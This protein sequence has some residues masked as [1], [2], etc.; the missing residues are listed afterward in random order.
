[1]NQRASLPD[2]AAK[3]G[4]SPH[5]WLLTLPL[6]AAVSVPASNRSSAHDTPPSSPASEE[7]RPYLTAISVAPFRFRDAVPPP[8]LTVRLPAGAP[9]EPGPAPSEKAAAPAPAPVA[10]APD[11]TVQPEPRD[12]KP[13][14]EPTPTEQPKSFAPILP[15][16]TRPK[17]R[18]EDFLP[19]FQYPNSSNIDVSV[20]A[21]ASP[22][23]MPNSS[24]SYRQQ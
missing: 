15:D 2:R 10:V 1:M 13:A 9:P 7:S 21:P 6:L 5:L 18:A 11:P 22:G 3:T 16:D 24:A 20:G 23:R 12:Q 8:D 17:V 19:F 14:P 4:R